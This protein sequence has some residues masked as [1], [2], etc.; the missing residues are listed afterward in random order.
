MTSW[1][2]CA[3]EPE[4]VELRPAHGI[5]LR[6]APCIAPAT[7]DAPETGPG[8]ACPAR[9][10]GVV[11]VTFC[12]TGGQRPAVTLLRPNL[13]R[14]KPLVPSL[15]PGIGFAPPEVQQG[16]RARPEVPRA[17]PGARPRRHGP[18][19]AHVGGRVIVDGG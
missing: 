14:H 9:R 19:R 18:L 6:G 11:P 1:A 15:P 17:W 7:H 4:P 8:M 2:K 3:T 12:L 13:L 10:G 5:T 16:Q